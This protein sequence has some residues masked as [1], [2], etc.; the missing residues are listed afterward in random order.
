MASDENPEFEQRKQKVAGIFSRAS[1]TY[2]SVGPRFFSHF[3]KRLVELTQIPAG[4]KVLDVASGKGSVLFPAGESVG[5]NGAVTGIDLAKGMVQELRKEI[6]TSKIAN[7]EVDQ[8][9]AEYLQFP[10]ASFD[11]VLC[12]FAIFFFPQLDRALSEIRRVLKP[13][14]RFAVTTWAESNRDDLKWYDDLLEIYLPPEEQSSDPQPPTGPVFN[15][16]EGLTNILSSGGFTDIQISNEVA[17]F[18]YKDEEEWWASIWSH[19]A[20][21]NLEEIEHVHGP[22][23]LERFKKE[24]FEKIKTIKQ[25]DGFHSSISVLFGL[26]KKPVG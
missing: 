5:F 1:T 19:G 12:G 3:G 16:P 17:E 14:G 10:D 2:D 4:A 18:T 7:I 8:M 23:G 15:T 11:I 20:R 22:D 25:V 6:A 24:A 26:S 21:A 13:G 9:D